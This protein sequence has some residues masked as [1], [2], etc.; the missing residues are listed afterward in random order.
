LLRLRMNK[1]LIKEAV[2]KETGILTEVNN[3]D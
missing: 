3:Y 2:E 1:V